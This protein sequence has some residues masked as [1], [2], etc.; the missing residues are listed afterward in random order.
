MKTFLK[1]LFL[2]AAVVASVANARPPSQEPMSGKTALQFWADNDIRLGWNLG[3][4]LD[5]VDRKTNKND[6]VATEG[7]WEWGRGVPEATQALFNGVKAS[8]FD[9]VRIPVTW[10]GHIGASPNYTVSEARLQRV[11]QVVDYAKTAG[12]KAVIINIHH[13]GNYTQPDKGT[14]GFVD[15][16]GA[17][18]DASKKT[19]IQDELGKVWTQI[20]NYFKN[21]GDYLIFET[22]NEVHQ[23]N[24]GTV[25]NTD[26]YRKQQDILFDWNG[27]ALSA[28]RATGGN[29]A[30]RFV[31]VPGLGSTE[32]ETVIN[33]HNRGKLL[34]SD[35]TNGTSKLIVS[36]HYYH[37]WQ[38][39]VA[40]VNG[41]D[42]TDEWKQP[43][44]GHPASAMGS[45]KSTFVD[46]GIA[47]YAGEWGAPTN[48][49]SGSNDNNIKATHREYIKTV[50][51]KAVENCVVP[52]YW[53]DGGNFKLLERSNGLAKTGFWSEVLSDIM[54]S[55]TPPPSSCPKSSS[56]S[57]S[58]RASSSSSGT[59]SSSS[60]AVSSSSSGDS[61]SSSEEDTSP[62]LNNPADVRPQVSSVYYYSLKGEPLGNVKPTKAG[63]YIFKQGS[64]IKKIAVR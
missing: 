6:W 27:A 19:A 50:A 38:Y 58:S 5:A 47:V 16:K 35:G 63:I 55:I 46:N 59:A 12:I 42:K 34:P 52:I 31:A 4:T 32:P 20:A 22:L 17:E 45:L 56:P 53:D 24:W 8:G 62:I 28:I 60:G 61:S 44:R 40:D 3:N 9:I 21:Y 15:L 13:D 39:T 7:L 10:I 37:P 23:G 30:T 14:W 33:A 51:A 64:S 54:A 18:N 41:T 25:A 26:A 43:E 11:S 36:V 49:R 57:S 48:V 1:A 2:A 29:N